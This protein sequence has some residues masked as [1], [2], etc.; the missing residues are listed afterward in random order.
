MAAVARVSPLARYCCCSRLRVA[1]FAKAVEE[2]SSGERIAGFTLVQTCVHTPSQL[3]ALQPIQDEQCALDTT[4][5]PQRYGKP[6]LT[7][8][9]AELAQHQRS[10]DRALLNRGGQ[11]QNFV[12]VGTNA[13]DL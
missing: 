1:D 3:D 8:I 7:W 12:P 6:V 5:F 9:A 4:E 2:Y 10:G 13:P 11:T